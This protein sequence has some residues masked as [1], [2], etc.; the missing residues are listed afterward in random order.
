MN[1]MNSSPFS[2][3]TDE[4]LSAYLDQEIS[5]EERALVEAAIAAEPDI[6]WRL[7]SLR[8]T[9]QL[10]RALPAVVLPKSF[11]L[12]KAQ[13]AT[14]HEQASAPL[15]QTATRVR[16]QPDPQTATWWETI[17]QSWRTFWQAGSPAL[18]N[19]AA[20]S[21]VLFF[22]LLGSNRFTPLPVAITRSPSEVA[23][24]S[25]AQPVANQMEPRVN[26]QTTTNQTE[27]PVAQLALKQVQAEEAESVSESAV[28]L[29]GTADSAGSAEKGAAALGNESA[30]EAASLSSPMPPPG[31]DPSQNL[32]PEQPAD[33]F[34]SARQAGP[35][36]VMASEESSP[37]TEMAA[38]HESMVSSSDIS[39]THTLA[40]QAA[41]TS[42]ATAEVQQ[43]ALVTTTSLMSKTSNSS[44]PVTVS[45]VTTNVH[46]AA[47]ASVSDR[48]QPVD[49]STSMEPSGG[50]TLFT[51]LPLAQLFSALATVVFAGFW[52]RS[53]SKK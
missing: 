25:T 8:Q 40:L 31:E 44:P 20:T 2:Q 33:V 16:R 24:A 37:L 23:P 9:V 47:A 21:F 29:A 46:P 12:T 14:N 4:M 13:L 48:V 51:L 49:D 52:W 1:V 5:P 15:R 3:V 34:A 27:A 36:T 42:E 38:V 50:S 28:P 11:V 19:A 18:R 10:L 6:A 22:V 41:D 17:Q 32:A 35:E 26:T 7:E 39:A 45:L 43:Q 53:R 30:V